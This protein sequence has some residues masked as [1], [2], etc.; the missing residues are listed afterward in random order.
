MIFAVHRFISQLRFRNYCPFLT[1]IS[2]RRH[3]KFRM[4]SLSSTVEKTLIKNV[5]TY[6]GQFVETLIFCFD[7]STIFHICFAL[8]WWWYVCVQFLFFRVFL[9]LREASIK[10][11]VVLLFL[12]TIFQIL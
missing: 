2:K 5:S 1:F 7:Y 3:E 8:R 4:L 9:L 10:K 11:I 12:R 6:V